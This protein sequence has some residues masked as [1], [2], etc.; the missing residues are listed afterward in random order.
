MMER[1][2]SVPTTVIRSFLK[3]TSTFTATWSRFSHGSHNIKIGADVKRN[4]ENSEFNVARPSYEF[5]DTIWFAAD[6][7]TLRLL[8]SPPGFVSGSRPSWPAMSGT[9]AMSNLELT[10][11]TTG[12]SLVA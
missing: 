6:A 11:R 8:A 4:I 10:F 1:R 3:N 2:D 9:G 12:K 7:L 5:T